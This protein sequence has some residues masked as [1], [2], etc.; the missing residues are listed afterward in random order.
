MK[1]YDYAIEYAKTFIGL[2]TALL[3][4]T[5]TF[6]KNIVGSD[7][8]VVFSTL[9]LVSWGLWLA[10]VYCGARGVATI[11]VLA[12]GEDPDEQDEADAD[13]DGRAEGVFDP[14][15]NGLLQR[16]R[17]FFLVGSALAI[18]TAFASL[19]VPPPSLE[20]AKESC[21]DSAGAVSAPDATQ[22]SVE[23]RGVTR[24][25]WF[26]GAAR[27]LTPPSSNQL[28][29]LCLGGCQLD[30]G[31]FPTVGSSGDQLNS[32]GLEGLTLALHFDPFSHCLDN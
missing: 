3:G 4:L 17:W 1:E 6:A 15:L 31:G 16:Q 14:E 27:P 10:S 24:T 29:Q 22:E 11:V 12:A 28:T 13:A 25:C 8:V 5:V 19:V 7:Y 2:T 18:L 23:G 9:L 21:V 20:S 30:L 26:D 32:L